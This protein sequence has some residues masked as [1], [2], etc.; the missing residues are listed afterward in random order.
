MSADV[1]LNIS[2]MYH[3]IMSTEDRAKHFLEN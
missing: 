2:W 1:S 3:E